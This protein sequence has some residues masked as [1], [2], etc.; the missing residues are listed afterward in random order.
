VPVAALMWR[1]LSSRFM[2][3]VL[4]AVV[5]AVLVAVVVSV[6]VVLFE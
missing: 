5:V 6:V 1:V 4:M 2:G 3:S